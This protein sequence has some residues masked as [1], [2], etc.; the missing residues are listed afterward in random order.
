M[1]YESFGREIDQNVLNEIFECRNDEKWGNPVIGVDVHLSLPMDLAIVIQFGEDTEHT[2]VDIGIVS[3]IAIVKTITAKILP[4]DGRRECSGSTAAFRLDDLMKI[5]HYNNDVMHECIAFSINA[6]KLEGLQ[7]ST[8]KKV[9]FV[10]TPGKGTV[11]HEAFSSE[12]NEL[13][14]LESLFP[15]P[16]EFNI[17]LYA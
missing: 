10:K 9:V 6:Y 5:S 17:V 15:L 12:D 1:Q 3:D 11:V 2:T 13:I 16:Q 7:E 8:T 4:D 14:N